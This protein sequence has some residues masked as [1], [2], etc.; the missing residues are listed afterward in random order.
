MMIDLFKKDKELN[1]YVYWSKS[2]TFLLP[3]TG[4]TKIPD[5]EF[6]AYV[7]WDE[8]SIHNYE[9][10]V[11]A[12]YGYRFEVF[13]EYLKT[14]LLY[15]G[16]SFAKEVYDFEGFSIMIF[17]ISEWKKD[18]DLFLIGKYSKFSSDAKSNI[19]DFHTIY[20]KKKQ[21]INIIIKSCI[22]PDVPEELLD[23]MTPLE[24]AIKHY[25]R[26][27]PRIKIDK[28]TEEA[29][30]KIGELCSKCDEEKETLI[31]DESQ[32]VTSIPLD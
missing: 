28:D 24:Y 30:L 19:V 23:N 9:L 4:I 5:I 13:E 3:L 14:T 17:D 32:I 15:N 8:Y 11:K 31:L 25:V 2:R 21:Q 16:K 22:Y 18:V 10:I 12:N 7:K 27:P 20:K 26:T 1:E 6:K 29:W